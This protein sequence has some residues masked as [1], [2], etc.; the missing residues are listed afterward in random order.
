VFD[1]LLGWTLLDGLR[2]L[3]GYAFRGGAYLKKAEE[4]RIAE[5]G[6]VFSLA[7]ERDPVLR[8]VKY[9]R[10]LT[11]WMV[12]IGLVFVW[13]IGAGVK[14]IMDSLGEATRPWSD[15][16]GQSLSDFPSKLPDLGLITLLAG[17]PFVL[18]AFTGKRYVSER[19][20][21]GVGTPTFRR[22]VKVVMCA[23]V[24]AVLPA[25]YLYGCTWWAAEDVGL[26]IMLFPVAIALGAGL[27]YFA[28]ILMFNP[29]KNTAGKGPEPLP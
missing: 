11:R 20:A 7:V 25:I 22:Y 28:G 18:I 6:P 3:L 5:L 8:Q 26:L 17:A 21:A 15:F 1:N 12:G 16:T 14:V 4:R 9:V 24:G 23:Y 27:G 2:D 29:E 13:I 10:R 19:V